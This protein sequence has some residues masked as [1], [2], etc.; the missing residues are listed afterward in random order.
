MIKSEEIE[1]TSSVEVTPDQVQRRIDDWLARLDNLFSLI[2]AWAGAHGWTWKEDTLPMYEQMMIDFEVRSRDQPSLKLMSAAG[3]F[4]W[5]KP[6]GLWVIGANGRVDI[7][8]P[9]G[10]FTLVDIAEQFE[11]PEWILHHVG[12]GKGEVFNPDQIAQ[13]V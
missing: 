4:V 13:M 1:E 3:D 11:K 12:H 6:K 10:A 8:A 2:K 9:K 7:Y 5:I